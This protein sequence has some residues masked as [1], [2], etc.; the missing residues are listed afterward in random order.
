MTIMW[1]DKIRH[2]YWNYLSGMV[3][4]CPPRLTARRMAKLRKL[5]WNDNAFWGDLIYR[6]GGGSTDPATMPPEVLEHCVS[7]FYGMLSAFAV[8]RGVMRP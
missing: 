3:A 7:N 4:Y 6:H 8:E 2:A 1:G 5:I